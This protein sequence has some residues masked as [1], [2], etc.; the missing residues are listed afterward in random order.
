MSATQRRGR[1]ARAASR[2]AAAGRKPSSQPRTRAE[3]NAAS[4][5]RTADTLRPSRPSK[6][7]REV[8]ARSLPSLVGTRH[9]RFLWGRGRASGTHARATSANWRATWPPQLAKTQGPDPGPPAGAAQVRSAKSRTAAPSA[10]PNA[11]RAAA[12]SR[13]HVPRPPDLPRSLVASTSTTRSKAGWA[14]QRSPKAAPSTEPRTQFT[15][16]ARDQ[17]WAR[18]NASIMTA[19]RFPMPQQGT[20]TSSWRSGVDAAAARTHAASAARRRM[21]WSQGL[22]GLAPLDDR[23]CQPVAIFVSSRNWRTSRD[24]A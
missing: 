24:D 16:G 20:T 23:L 8:T 14:S 15:D 21:G 19:M 4:S 2:T 22:R 18:A 12:P 17:A 3:Q 13:P 10:K 11:D 1:G 7:S 6:K 9:T 5:T